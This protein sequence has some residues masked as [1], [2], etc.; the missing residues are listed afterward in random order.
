MCR[1]T[2]QTA[3]TRT[4]SRHVSQA[5]HAGNAASHLVHTRGKLASLA[6]TLPGCWLW[7]GAPLWQ[8]C[9]ASHQQRVFACTPA[10]GAVRSLHACRGGRLNT[11]PPS[12]FPHVLG[13]P[14]AAESTPGYPLLLPSVYSVP[15]FDGK[16]SRMPH[17]DLNW[18]GDGGLT[19]TAVAQRMSVLN[20]TCLLEQAAEH[21]W[22]W[23]PAALTTPALTTS[24]VTRP[25]HMHTC[26]TA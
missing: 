3:P 6:A 10:V 16:T 7:C 4:S 23:A 14:S 20:A 11:A 17:H 26:S 15:F 1:A 8:P 22:P 9:V 18:C 25:R 19:P 13:S 21:S 12:H 24:R 5:M 2:T